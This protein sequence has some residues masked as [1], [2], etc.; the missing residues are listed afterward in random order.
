V[1]TSAKEAGTRKINSREK[2]AACKRNFPISSLLAFLVVINFRMGM[3]HKYH[4]IMAAKAFSYF[5]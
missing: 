3:N 5:S 4:S 1:T 2:N